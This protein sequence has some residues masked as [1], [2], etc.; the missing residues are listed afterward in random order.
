MARGFAYAPAVPAPTVT[1]AVAVRGRHPRF[2]RKMVRRPKKPIPA[3]S[4]VWVV[5]RNG[6]QVGTG[7]YNPRTDLALRMFDDGFV[8]DPERLLV[9]R[10]ADAV[11]LR[12]RTFDLGQ[13]SNAYRLVHA[14]GD[15]LPGLILDKLGDALVAECSA[16]G[17]QRALEPLGEW[18]VEH[19]PQARLVLTEDRASGKKEGMERIPPPRPVETVVEEFGITYRVAAGTGH[20][21]GFFADQRDNRQLV[22]SLARGRRVVDVCC[23]AG[24]FALNAAAGG[25]RSVR[26]VDLDEAAV[27]QAEANAA[28]NRQRIETV[29]EDGFDHLRGLRRGAA[30]LLIL[31]PPKWV[32]H[33]KELD[34]GLARYRDF[35]RLG[36]AALEPG[37]ILVTCSCSGS[38]SEGSF[39]RM[40]QDAATLAGRDARVL[41]LR[42]AGVDHPVALEFPEGRYLKVAVLQVL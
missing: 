23:H 16:L 26:A 3:G 1:L 8:E 22:R 38:V 17:T 24:G 14:E 39:V 7:F 42:G 29:H 28:A 21:T 32:A 30:D 19:Y 34:E 18:L 41:A 2:F 15:R 10:L 35:N 9:A 4:V 20:K 31:D 11:A 37:G 36:I 12:E 27:A 5:D 40:L 6:K 25:A 33:R 13:V